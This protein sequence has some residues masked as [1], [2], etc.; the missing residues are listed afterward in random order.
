MTA[1]FSIW[2]ILL[3]PWLFLAPLA[4]MAFD[5]GPTFKTYVFVWSIWTYPAAVGIAAIVR[6][7]GAGDWIASLLK[8]CGVFSLWIVIPAV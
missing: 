5:A 6:K 1:L 2:L 3:L 4:P 8:R 7:K